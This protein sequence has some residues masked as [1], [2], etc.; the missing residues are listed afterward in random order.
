[1]KTI[2]NILS[3]VLILFISSCTVSEAQT[4]EIRTFSGI[5]GV[6]LTGSGDV[7]IE[8]GNKEELTISAPAELIPFLVTELKDGT[9]YIGKYKK[10]WK[11]FKNLHRN[12]RYDLIVETINHVGVS[13]SGD[14][15]AEKL[16]GNQCTV[17]VSGS[18]N[19]DV[20]DIDSDKLKIHISGSGDI[21]VD[22]ISTDELIVSVNG[23]GDAKI[24]GSA[25]E[26]DITISGSGDFYGS[27][28]NSDKVT[29]QLTGSGNA[30]VWAVETLNTHIS[31]SGD[32]YYNGDPS[33]HTRTTGSGNVRHR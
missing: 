25:D 11:K 30:N 22:K 10:G 29:V 15:D 12:I 13:G 17:K 32:V 2:N 18:G 7:T 28:L 19:I 1:M 24:I 3:L 27:N 26:I 4:S 31:G 8:L 21:E 33:I 9:L 5:D 23:S 16:E 14:L 6:I 20:N